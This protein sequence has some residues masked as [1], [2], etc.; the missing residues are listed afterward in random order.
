MAF[1][2]TGTS[3]GTSSRRRL[4]AIIIAAVVL[5]AA[6]IGA[7][8]AGATVDSSRITAEPF[9]GRTGEATASNPA[10]L[11]AEPSWAPMIDQLYEAILHRAA[12]TA[13]RRFWGGILDAKV[14]SGTSAANA[15]R[16]VADEIAHSPEAAAKRID[17]AYQSLLGR[18]ADAAGR[19]YWVPF[20]SSGMSI[21][22]FWRVL[23]ET[24]EFTGQSADTQ[25]EALYATVLGRVPD[26]S[27]RAFWVSWVGVHGAVSMV[28]QFTTS[29]EYAHRAVGEVYRDVL[30]RSPDPLGLVYWSAQ[31]TSGWLGAIAI[32]IALAGSA[33]SVAYGCDPTSRGQCLLPFPN[34]RYTRAD[35]G[36]ATGRRVNLKPTFTPANVGGVHID[37]EQINRSDGFSPGAPAIVQVPGLDLTVTPGTPTVDQPSKSLDPDSPVLVFDASTGAKWPI[38]AEID[39]VDSDDPNPVLFIRPQTNY[40]EG[41]TYVV[42]LRNLRNTDG[43][44]IPPSPVFDAYLHGTDLPGVAGFADHKAATTHIL[45][46]LES[47]GVARDGM[48]LAWQFTV[49]ST[50][51]LTGRLVHIRDDAFERLGG[52][53]GLTNDAAPNFTITSVDDDPEWDGIARDIIGT[54]DVPSYLTGDGSPGSVFDTGPDGLPRFSGTTYTAD[55]RCIVGDAALTTPGIPTVYGHGL[56]GTLNQVR[57]DSQRA[58]VARF[59]RVY[60][61]TDEIGMSDAD[62]IPSIGI[63]QDLSRF[64]E[65]VDRLQQGVLNE[66]FL[67]RLLNSPQGFATNAAFQNASGDPLIEAHAV[68]YD[69]NSQGGI[70]GG[71]V[72]AVSTDFTQAVLG[73]TGTDYATLMDRSTDFAPFFAVLNSSYPARID[74]TIALDLIQ[75]QWD[76]SE[77]NGYS[78]HMID[79]LLPNTPAHKVLMLLSYGDHQVNNWSGDVQARTIGRNGNF[80]ARCPVVASNRTVGQWPLWNVPCIEAFPYAGSGVVYNDTG[81]DPNPFENVPPVEDDPTRPIET[82]DPHNDPQNTPAIQDLKNGFMR[83][84]GVMQNTCGPGPCQFP[85][86]A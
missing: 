67:A 75:M 5:A 37:T 47:W 77:P 61:S 72:T 70:L 3:T 19:A 40:I 83:R 29:V 58:M 63:L 52:P 24:P 62:E 49:A 10:A 54:Y 51:N 21:E 45:D 25:V 1:Q 9:A 50:T 43:E 69:G 28:G 84:D 14:S 7:A 79:D 2:M 35:P 42:A 16:G 46:E 15:A 82:R 34:D 13:D 56:F 18:D 74:Q 30:R 31:V 4:R 71:V 85:P 59:G 76:R 65:L 80:R 38:W 55:F 22:V 17:A 44:A 6:S 39:S 68:T 60:C 73:T 86:P 33:E 81:A 27:G 11:P 23:A 53:D 32:Q 66:L 78:A 36:T 64:P 20:I 8:P 26:V 48:Y 41:H 57:S 12:T